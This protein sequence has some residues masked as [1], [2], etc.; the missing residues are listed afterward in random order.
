MA[1]KKVAKKKAARKKSTKKKSKSR[2]K[3]DESAVV[4]PSDI[5]ARTYQIWEQKG[6]PPGTDQENW[7][8]AVR[9]LT[10]G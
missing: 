7:D 3:A 10:G 8:Q 4:T 5:A 2:K 1:K 6:R 9:E